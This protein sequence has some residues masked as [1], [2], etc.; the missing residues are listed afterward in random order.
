MTETIVNA[1]L[2]GTDVFQISAANGGYPYKISLWLPPSYRKSFNSYPVIYMLDASLW[3][4]MAVSTTLPLIWGQEIPEVIIVGVGYYHQGFDDIA[5]DRDRDLTPTSVDEIKGSGGAPAFL[6]FLREE[7]IPRLD[8]SYRTIPSNRTIWGTSLSG[9]FVLYSFLED[10]DLFSQY[11]AASPALAWD[12]T[13]FLQRIDGLSPTRIDQPRK[14]FLSVGA[15]ED[16][17]D[18]ERVNC[19]AQSIKQSNHPMIQVQ[20]AMFENETHFSQ[21]ARSYV[22]GLRALFAGMDLGSS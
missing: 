1:R 16:F 14:L 22:T 8:K 21:G 9:L 13:G 18:R 5:G 11:I 15:H 6:S 19:L 10:P 7:L 12:L 4:G 2:F 17:A 3:F 20:T